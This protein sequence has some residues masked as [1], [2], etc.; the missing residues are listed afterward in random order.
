MK[1][2]VFCLSLFLLV[3]TG[4]R[5]ASAAVVFTHPNPQAGAEFG[6]SMAFV[7]DVDGDGVPDLLVG[8][9]K[10]DVGGNT[11]QGQVYLLSGAT[12]MLIRTLDNPF[13]Q[14]DARFGAAVASAG[15]IDGDGKND[16]LIGAPQQNVGLCQIGD[17]TGCSVGQAFVFSS[18][19][20][21]LLRT[22]SHPFPHSSS[23]FGSAVAPIGDINGDVI[24]D[25]VIGVPGNGLGVFVASYVFV[26]S[27]ADGS[28]LLT[29]TDP[30]SVEAEDER[31]FTFGAVVVSLDDVNGDGKPDILV[32]D[33]QQDVGGNEEQ[34]QVHIFSGA[35]GSLIRTINHPNPQAEAFSEP[36]QRLYQTSVVTASVTLWW[37]PRG[38][39]SG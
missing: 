35:D 39:M 18:V 4:Y 3:S 2:L 8:A 13:P 38:K 31:G 21:S 20:G 12:G 15:D 33:G 16:L 17:T 1:A 7:G 19:T 36:R 32:G 30:N 22:L 14:P 11:D 29:L 26:F 9:P 24:R 27:G 10:Q 23:F 25:H 6:S 37:G 5:V 34:G 28:L